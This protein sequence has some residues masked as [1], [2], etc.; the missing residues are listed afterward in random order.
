[1]HARKGLLPDLG[2]DVEEHVAE[3]AARR[4]AHEDAQGPR[5]RRPRRH[6]IQRQ[7]T[8]GPEPH[9]ARHRSRLSVAG[10]GGPRP[11]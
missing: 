6:R 7:E 3:E 4:E 10:I 11:R 1:M 9:R 5:V 8:H 2:E